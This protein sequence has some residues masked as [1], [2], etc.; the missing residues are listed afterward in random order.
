MI[1]AG[2]LTRDDTRRIAQTLHACLRNPQL[3]SGTRSD[4]LSFLQQL[5]K[6]LQKG[7]L[8][9]HPFVFV[10]ILGIYK[11]R[12]MYNEGY[13]LW[14][15]LVQQDDTHVS[16]AVY[17][18]AI[19]MMAYGK[20]LRLYELENLYVDALKRFPGTFAEYHLSPDA[21]VPNRSQPTVIA[22]VPVTL[23]QGILTARLLYNDW[24]NAY[25]A[26][27]TALRLYPCQLPPRFFEMFMESRQLGEAYTTFLV[28]CR[29]GNVLRPSHVTTLLSKIR[30]SIESCDTLGDRIVLVRAIANALYAYLE[31]GGSLEPIHAGQFLTSFGSLLPEPSPG[32]D[33]QGDTALL[34]N[35][36]ITF[37]HGT[38]SSLLQAGMPPSPQVFSALV[39]LAGRL[40]V[41]DLL[42]VSLQDA[43]TA[44]VDLGDIGIRGVMFSAG[45]TG[46]KDL[47][48]EFWTRIAHKA[49]SNGRQIDWKDWV[50][51]AKACKRADHVDYF[52][53]QLR[54]QEHAI[55]A[56]SKHIVMEALDEETPYFERTIDISRSEEFES[57]LGELDQQIK[58]ITAVVM[59]GQRLDIRNTPFYMFLDP[60]RPPLARLE[61]MQKVYNEYT[62]D[63]H[64]PPPETST[65]PA[66]LSPTGLPLDELRFANWVSVLELMDQAHSS[67]HE[68]QSR[69]KRMGQDMARKEKKDPLK[70]DRTGLLALNYLRD[71][72]RSMRDTSV[73]QSAT[74]KTYTPKL[75]TPSL[76]N[77]AHATKDISDSETR[78]PRFQKPVRIIKHA[79]GS[80]YRQIDI[81]QDAQF[82]ES[83]QTTSS[84]PPTNNLQVLYHMFPSGG[85]I[86]KPAAASSEPD[87]PELDA[88]STSNNI[89]PGYPRSPD[90]KPPSLK[91]YV[92]V[93]SDHEAPVSIPK[94]SR[95][96]LGK[97]KYANHHSFRKY[98]DGQKAEGSR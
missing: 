44:Q 30:K 71:H 19:E 68:R 73:G 96:P 50:S 97:R 29:A 64:Q 52:R 58:N 1:A 75:I 51:F 11:E 72:V 26:L 89:L 82:P 46:A 37:A 8:P 66:A 13:A 17:G 74:R 77:E 24:K 84:R 48:E 28:A 90:L 92:S 95:N 80:S 57:E 94:I 56:S 62:I 59:S 85:K 12:K 41:P 36:I 22:D 78:Q 32:S 91:K 60:K 88:A 15:W 18:A 16:Q 98:L 10:H 21:I 87:A 63:P 69:L 35:R 53:A 42:R 61:D 76:P 40:R 81:S 20:K 70:R 86:L 67:E 25:L 34:R 47:I 49:A 5:I 31:A 43:D 4:L 27:D 7:T 3:L 55:P 33:Y 83:S 23:L 6:D 54:E 93:K 79:R 65:T 38:L 9:T 45:Q 14:Q 39:N 2:T